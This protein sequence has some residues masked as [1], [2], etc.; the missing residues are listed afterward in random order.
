MK[1][2][3]LMVAVA[4]VFGLTLYLSAVA[5]NAPEG[6]PGQRQGRGGLQLIHFVRTNMAAQTIA[7]LT[8]LPVDELRGELESQSLPAVLAAHHVDRKAFAEGLRTRFQNLLG[9][10]GNSGYLTADQK[11]RILA[12]VEQRVQRRSIMKGL[13]D[14]GVSDGTITPEQAQTLFNRP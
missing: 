4:L 6:A 11:S 8:N 13:I 12:Q 7:G 9:Q 3:I 5:A 2:G 1:K 10:L 14:K